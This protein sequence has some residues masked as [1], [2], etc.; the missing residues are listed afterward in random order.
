MDEIDRISF[1]ILKLGEP[2]V[3]WKDELN[4]LDHLNSRNL[5]VLLLSVEK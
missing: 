1:R 3:P 5:A 2:T 4:H